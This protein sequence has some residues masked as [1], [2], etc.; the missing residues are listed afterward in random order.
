MKYI[1]CDR[2]CS[3]NGR[4]TW[5]NNRCIVAGVA[6]VAVVFIIA[7]VVVAVAIVAIVVSIAIVAVVAGV[8]GVA[9]FSCRCIVC[10]CSN[11]QSSGV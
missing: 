8:A 6:V 3:G 5:C 10:G 7:V 9:G 2:F 1:G 4:W 11:I